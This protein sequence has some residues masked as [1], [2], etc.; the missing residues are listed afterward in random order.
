MNAVAQRPFWGNLHALEIASPDPEGLAAFYEAALGMRTEE[1]QTGWNCRG[2]DRRLRFVKGERGSLS[3]AGYAL[4]HIEVL[5]GLK[6]RLA[7]AG[8]PFDTVLNA[9][10]AS[11]CVKFKD[12]DG[13]PFLFGLPGLNHDA[14]E[15]MAARLQHVVLASQNAD[16]LSMFFQE[17]VG[18]RLSDRVNDEAGLMRTVFLR[19]N[20]EHHSLAIFQAS[21]KRFDHHC[22]EADDWNAI[23]DWGDHFAS[24]RLP[25]EWGP[26]RHGPGN[27]LFIF[28]NDP[29]NNW[30]E[31]SA[32]LEIVE[33]D[34][35]IGTW[36]HEERTLNIWG[37]GVLRT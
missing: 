15:G 22:Y 1:D 20:H 10:F 31:I 14:Q 19:S 30:V 24:M 32:E 29:D 12:P 33:A 35:P 27:N 16:H 3:C 28:V 9:D 26:G 13:N 37:R 11:E 8:V 17:V 7:A 6:Q 23:R 4:E 2:P 21:E 34:R 5:N 36:P 25:V 18:F